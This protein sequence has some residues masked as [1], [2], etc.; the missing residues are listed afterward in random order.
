MLE[1]AKDSLNHCLEEENTSKVNQ[2]HRERHVRTEK[3]DPPDVNLNAFRT[4]LEICTTG[5]E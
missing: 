3:L 5:S 4:I 2:Q 1:K